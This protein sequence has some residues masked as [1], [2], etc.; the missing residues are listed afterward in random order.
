MEEKFRHP[1]LCRTNSGN[2]VGQIPATHLND[3]I[4]TGYTIIFILHFDFN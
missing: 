3:Y 2:F 4:S 1:N